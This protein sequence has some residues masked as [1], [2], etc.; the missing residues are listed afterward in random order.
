MKS[1]SKIAV[2]THAFERPSQLSTGQD[3]FKAAA[4]K[5]YGAIVK[6]FCLCALAALSAGAILAAIIASEAAFYLRSLSH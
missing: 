4:P 1:I 6:R 5:A 3:V 2:V